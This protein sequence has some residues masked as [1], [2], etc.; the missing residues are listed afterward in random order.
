MRKENHQ[1]KNICS[2]F[3]ALTHYSAATI[4]SLLASH[5]QSQFLKQNDIIQNHGENY[6]HDTVTAMLKIVVTFIRF[7]IVVMFLKK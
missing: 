1:M 5:A 7:M 2:K 4:L 6:L 3:H